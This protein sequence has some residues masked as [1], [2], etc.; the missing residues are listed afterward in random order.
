MPS[1]T[2]RA[3]SALVVGLGNGVSMSQL[4]AVLVAAVGDPDLRIGVW[5]GNLRRYIDSDGRL[6]NGPRAGSGRAVL[7][8]D[9]N[10]QPVAAIV[11]DE[12][13]VAEP[14][15]RDAAATA[16]VLAIDEQH[17]E[18]ELMALRAKAVAAGDAERMRIVR[19][20]HDSAQQQL[21]AL[22][23]RVA[24]LLAGGQFEGKQAM[25]DRLAAELDSSIAELRS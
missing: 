25:T 4:R 19:D 21:V 16:T 14:E 22:R 15:L 11:A 23:V 2:P 6:S 5:D 18:N 20:L 9:R 12:A 24:L 8:I 13:V 17:I 3:P 7:P 1:I 10:G